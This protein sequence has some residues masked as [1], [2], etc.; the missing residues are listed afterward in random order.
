MERTNVQDSVRVGIIPK[1]R[2]WARISFGYFEL[3]GCY[4]EVGP[5]ISSGW[6][7]RAG[8]VRVNEHIMARRSSTFALHIV[9]SSLLTGCTYTNH[10]RFRR[11]RGEPVSSLITPWSVPH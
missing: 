6:Q 8:M 10:G 5:V 7:G 2:S 9:H 1:A 3:E 11:D 4:S